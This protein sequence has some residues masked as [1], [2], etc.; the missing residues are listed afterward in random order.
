M[1]CLLSE[2]MQ[3]ASG[4]ASPCELAE[5]AEKRDASFFTNKLRM[6]YSKNG[7]NKIA[8]LF[9]FDIQFDPARNQRHAPQWRALLTAEAN[10]KMM[11]TTNHADCRSGIQIV[12]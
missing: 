9:A 7:L 6:L 3:D 4:K 1:G 2:R 5:I 12:A 10:L 8:S 11:D